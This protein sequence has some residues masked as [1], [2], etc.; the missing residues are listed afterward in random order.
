MVQA[1]VQ[2]VP[3]DQEVV[4]ATAAAE[5]EL[6]VIPVMVV[7]G[8]QQAAHTQLDQQVTPDKSEA[9][10]AVAV[11][12]LMAVVVV[13]V[14]LA[15]EGVALPVQ[16]HLALVIMEAVVLVEPEARD[17]EAL[18]VAGVTVM[19]EA[20]EMVPFASFG[21]DQPEHSHILA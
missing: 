5:A 8:E 17:Q 11:E 10:V 21:L 19:V 6:Q 7:M 9:A 15:K 12:Q 13:L 18:T 2:V 20:E 3:V 4:H 1:V 14:Y 16:V